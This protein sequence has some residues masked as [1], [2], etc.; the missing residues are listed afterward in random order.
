MTD[1]LLPPAERD[2]NGAGDWI[3]NPDGTI[4]H[5]VVVSRDTTQP[6]ETYSTYEVLDCPNHDRLVNQVIVEITDPYSW[7]VRLATE[8]QGLGV[9][10]RTL[11]RYGMPGNLEQTGGF[12][13][14]VSVTTGDGGTV[15]AGGDPGFYAYYPS[16]TWHTNEPETPG[17]TEYRSRPEDLVQGFL[18][19]VQQHGGAVETPAERFELDWA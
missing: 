5:H 11:T 19:V 4:T 18:A 8:D 7:T 12:C 15:C 13:M 2:T 14:V 17:Y 16:T 1:G 9:L 6:Y 3:A 10:I